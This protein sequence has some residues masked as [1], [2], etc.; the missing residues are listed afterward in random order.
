MENYHL[1]SVRGC[2]CSIWWI[3]VYSELAK[4]SCAQPVGLGS[5][6]CT[7]LERDGRWK[8]REED[9]LQGPTKFLCTGLSSKY[10]RLWGP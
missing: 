1:P 4:H 6:C 9:L 8:A 5:Q 3:S 7:K 10:F 2:R